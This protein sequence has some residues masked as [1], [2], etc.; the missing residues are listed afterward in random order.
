MVVSLA[1]LVATAAGNRPSPT[2]C[3]HSD[4]TF[5]PCGPG[6]DLCHAAGYP[7]GTAPNYHVRDY[8]CAMNDPA[9]VIYDPVHAMY[10]DHW[11]DHLAQPGG[12]YVLGHAVSRDLV[13]CVPPR[14]PLVPLLAP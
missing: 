14:A 4:G 11:E 13:Q 12:Q 1:A 5:A 2:Q 7:N 10:H 3:Q 9:A 6:N 8:S